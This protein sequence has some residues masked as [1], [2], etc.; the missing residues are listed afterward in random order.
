M[1]GPQTN[2]EQEIN[3]AYGSRDRIAF[4]WTGGPGGRGGPLL[5]VMRGQVRPGNQGGI[6]P[7]MPLYLAM[8]KVSVFAFGP[9]I[10]TLW[11]GMVRLA[12]KLYTWNITKYFSKT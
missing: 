7:S 12:Q 6:S 4:L 2:T 5:L 8:N 11:A 3:G 9:F 10:G 1:T